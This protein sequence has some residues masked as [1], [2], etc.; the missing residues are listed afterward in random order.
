MRKIEIIMVNEN[1]APFLQELMNNESVMTALNETPTTVN[2]W[3]AAI[4]EWL[5]DPDEE[6]YIIYDDSKPIGWLG[7]N[8]L[9]A[10]D[11]KAYIKMIALFPE[12]QNC[13]IGQYAISEIIENLVLR[14]YVSIGLYTD[15]SNIQAQQCYLKCG[16]NI[17][18]ETEQKMSNGAVV[19][20]YIMEK[21]IDNSKA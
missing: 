17:T 2:I 15:Q 18:S 13:G 11:K 10:E 5:Q 8:G 3:T 4:T 19:K 12:Y 7:I 9:S 6:D 16:F 20:R 21:F 1:D 14:G